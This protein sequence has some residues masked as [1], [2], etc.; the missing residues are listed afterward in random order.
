MVYSKQ[1]IETFLTRRV[2]DNNYLK[3]MSEA[4]LDKRLSE[5]RV[6]PCFSSP[7]S[8]HQKVGFLVALAY[9]ETFIQYQMGLGKTRL[10]LELIKYFLK[11][12]HKHLFLILAP[13][14]EVVYGWSEEIEK[15][16]PELP[17]SLL[18]GGRQE[19]WGCLK[20]VKNGT[21]IGTYIGVATMVSEL[22]HVKDKNGKESE[23]RS[24]VPNIELVNRLVKPLTGVVYDE[25]TRVKERSSL[26]YEIANYVS[27]SVKIRYALAGRPFGRDP[28]ALW[29]QFYLVDRGKTLSPTYGLFREIF[30]DKVKSRYGGPYNFDY[31]FKKKMSDTLA[32]ITAHRSIRY[33]E[34]ECLNLPPVLR[35]IKRVVFPAEN[36]QY[37]Q[38]V[39]TQLIE[40]KGN[41]R[42]A[43]N[44]F[45]QMRQLSS[46]FIGLIDDE[47]SERVQV[48]FAKNAKLDLLL[49]LVESVPDDRKMVIFHEFNYSGE[50]ISA[51]LK[52]LGIQHGRLHG[53]TKDWS[54]MKQKFDNDNHYR[55]MVINSK[56]GAY[57]LNLQRANY[58]F[59]YE[60]PVSVIDRE[61]A[62]KRCHR[63][64]QTERVFIYDLVVKDTC[65]DKIL[66]FH[67][68]GADILKAL[69][70]NPNLARGLG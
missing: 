58:V 17:Y 64:G 21:I 54:T 27:Q 51:A 46:G 2:D 57:G 3:G 24:W 16:M 69:V 41:L 44:A 70:D 56:K 23:K 22:I 61:Q 63:Q 62:E 12:N 52:K 48:K 9:Q 37:Y 50:T 42:E 25:S 65:D 19:K 14:D 15:W 43:K 13:T 49:E 11:L 6:P 29:A 34:E 5:L 7:L 10:S 36:A 68:E 45:L 53:G 67:K 28:L 59:F 18:T 31:K 35:I 55:A 32:R 4:W 47:S 8:K 66:Q 1:A 40:A 33:T 20:K 60:S 39:I 26:S 38:K 30:F